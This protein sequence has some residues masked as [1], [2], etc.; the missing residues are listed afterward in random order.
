MRAMCVTVACVLAVGCGIQEAPGTG[1]KIGQI[2]RV[3]RTGILC[4]TWEAQILRGGLSQ[5][6]GAFGA[7]FHFTITTSELAD[8]VTKAMREQTEVLIRYRAPGV[9]YS[10]CSSDSRGVYLESIIPVR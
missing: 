3:E 6:S 5:G 10:R 1:E 7:P 4:Q 2:V 9:F 8:A